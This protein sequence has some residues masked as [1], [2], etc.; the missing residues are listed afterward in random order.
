MNENLAVK[1]K[2]L[3]RK[4]AIVAVAMFGFGYAFSAL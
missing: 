4:L 3:G 2:R 1:N